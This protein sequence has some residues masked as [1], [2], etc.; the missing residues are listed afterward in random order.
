LIG[1]PVAII[2]AV[3]YI[4]AGLA[5]MPASSVTLGYLH[6]PAFLAIS[7]AGIVCAPLGAKLASVMPTKILQRSFSVCMILVGAKML[8]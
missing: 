6:W 7:A 8:I 1:L 2:G 4:F 5:H 3:T